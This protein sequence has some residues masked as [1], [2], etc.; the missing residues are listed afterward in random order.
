MVQLSD[1]QHDLNVC[2]EEERRTG[3]FDRI[4]VDTVRIV[5]DAVRIVFD[6]VRIVVA[7]RSDPPC[8]HVPC[9][10]SSCGNRPQKVS[11]SHDKAPILLCHNTQPN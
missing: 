5:F 8:S 2:Q 3:T 11:P 7:G 6:A 4:V 9:H 1:H 10:S